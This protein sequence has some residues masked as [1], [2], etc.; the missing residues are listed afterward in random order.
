MTCPNASG[1]CVE[2]DSTRYKGLCWRCLRPMP[3]TI[4]RD[5][6]AE[7]A[8]IRGAAEAFS[9]VARS[10]LPNPDAL[11]DFAQ[12]RAH[13]GPVEVRDFPREMREELADFAN[14]ASWA[15]RNIAAGGEDYGVPQDR[16]LRALS[17]VT[18]AYAELVPDDE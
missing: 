6:R 17:L 7:R 16:V 18:A 14:Y 12:V 3:R 5:E 4:D 2:S 10:A 9:Q 1:P 13:D 11:T 8:Y 15:V